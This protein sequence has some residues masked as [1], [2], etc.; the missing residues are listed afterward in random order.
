MSLLRLLTSGKSLVSLKDLES[1]YQLRPRNLLPKFGS[2]RNPF[3]ARAQATKQPAVMNTAPQTAPRTG[4]PTPAELEAANLKETKRLPGISPTTEAKAISRPGV[5]AGVL[6]RISQ[7]AR[8]F[9]PL[10]W[11]GDRRSAAKPAIPGFNHPP[12][13]GEL[14]LD[15]IKVVRNDLNDADLEVIPAKPAAKTKPEAV[16]QAHERAELAATQPN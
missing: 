2:A 13:Q 12:V 6:H 1:R 7:I 15:N 4:E 5:A 10:G 3:I 9:N 16:M 8:K 11:R 14:S